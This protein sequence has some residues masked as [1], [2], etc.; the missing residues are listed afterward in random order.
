MRAR[1]GRY[2]GKDFDI[3]TA[4]LFHHVGNGKYACRNLNFS[5]KARGYGKS[6][7]KKNQYI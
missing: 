3:I 2:Y 6:D 4:D 1:S 7:Q 5:R